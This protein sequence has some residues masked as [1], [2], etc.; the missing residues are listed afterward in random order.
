[1][2]SGKHPFNLKVSPSIIAGNQGRLADEVIA[3]EAA[4]ADMIHLD[5]MDGHFVPNLTMGPGVVK[6][7]RPHARITFDTHL[8][9]QEPWRYIEA[10]AR[11]GSDRIGIHVEIE[12]SRIRPSLKMIR[13]LGVSPG[14][15]INPP[16]PAESLF[17]Y[18]DLVD[19]VL[20][21]T[22]NPGFYGQSL[23][24]EALDKLA[25]LRQ[26]PVAL[27]RNITFQVDGGVNASN[28]GRVAR[29]GADEV[30]GGAAVMKA[31]SYREAIDLLRRGG[32]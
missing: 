6:D 21:M 27:S 2:G 29:A 31:A 23:I 28:I 16:T 25:V 3:L 26:N 13:D 19:F 22:V 4:G 10:F 18:L 11:A 32:D 5:I 7:L 8:M 12:Q 30:V 1:M 24:P 20:V 17:E 14:I 15:V 9:L